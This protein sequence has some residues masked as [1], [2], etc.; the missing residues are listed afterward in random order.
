MYLRDDLKEKYDL[1]QVKNAKKQEA[2]ELDDFDS[3]SE[4]DE[5]LRKEHHNI[6]AEQKMMIE[7]LVMALIFIGFGI[8]ITFFTKI[9]LDVVC[10]T[11][12]LAA[13]VV[14]IAFAISYFIKNAAGEYYQYDLVY[15][16]FAIMLSIIMFARREQL[17]SI[18]PLIM[19]ILV[20]ANGM[21]KLQHSLDMKR[22]DKKTKTDS[23]NWIYVLIFA[24]LCMIFGIII[25]FSTKDVDTTEFRL[26]GIAFIFSGVTDIV[27]MFSLIK[28]I[29]LF[30]KQQ[31]ESEKSS[32]AAENA[33]KSENIGT[34]EM[35]QED[36]DVKDGAKSAKS[37]AK[38]E[39]KS[40]VN[41]ESEKSKSDVKTEAQENK[42]DAPSDTKEPENP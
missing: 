4:I 27:T 19:G 41:E 20:A 3:A 15:G 30:R 14:G 29:R 40:E 34:S 2:D 11:F 13:G 5:V 8:E 7:T 37:E 10:Y 24:F 33:E 31:E 22:L 32:A 6:S 1:K 23:G 17:K 18:I 16:L 12:S 38:E 39:L 28:K 42:S 26:M 35:C 36:T 9:T 21:V 25:M